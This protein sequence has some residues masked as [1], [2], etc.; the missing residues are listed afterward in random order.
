MEE[1]T[2]PLPPASPGGYPPR[3]SR[4]LRRFLGLV[5]LGARSE[6][7]AQPLER[8]ILEPEPWKVLLALLS[9][10]GTHRSG[11]LF[12]SVASG[13]AHITDAA[14]AG[15]PSL[16]SGAGATPLAVDARY[17]LG[18]SDCLSVYS[19][20]N[21]DWRGHWLMLPDN[22][23]GNSLEHDA[24][25]RRAQRQGLVDEQHFLLLI[26]QDGERVAC[27]AY[28]FRDDEVV[29]LEVDLRRG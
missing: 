14:H 23:F 8:V 21:V 18:W 11:A 28:L 7:E 2:E 26:G 19:S 29:P 22:R 12:G 15:Y 1:Y 5:A 16:N 10:P 6:A 27:A 17:L 3:V 4:A 24:W 20:N 9:S 25:V 13:L